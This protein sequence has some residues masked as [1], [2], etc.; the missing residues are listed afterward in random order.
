MIQIKIIDSIHKNDINLPNDYFDIWGRL[1]PSYT[2]DSWSYEII[3]NDTI[4]QMKFPDECYNF[5]EMNDYIFIGAY[6]NDKC[7]GLLVLRHYFF[8]YMYLH[9]LKVKK[10]YRGKHV[11]KMLIEKANEVAKDFR[12]SGIYT[13][14]QDNNLSACLFYLNNGFYIGGIDTNVYKHTLQ[15][16]KIDLILYKEC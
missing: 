11:G 5:N 12:Y 16:G 2:N 10:E 1:K 9:D 4:T 3:K 13:I 15:E 6:D 14:V 8:K 7:I